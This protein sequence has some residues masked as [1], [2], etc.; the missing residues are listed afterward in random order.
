MKEPILDL[1]L[2]IRLQQINEQIELEQ[3]KMFL[4]ARWI[5]TCYADTHLD[6]DMKSEHDEG[7]KK[8]E[9]ISV[10]NREDGQWYKEQLEFFN[11]K[12]LPVYIKNGNYDS[13]KNFLFPEDKKE[14]SVEEEFININ[15][16]LPDKG[17]DILGKTSPNSNVVYVFR[18]NCHNKNCKE[19]RCS[20]TG[21][22]MLV[23][24]YSWKYAETDEELKQKNEQKSK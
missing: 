4:F 13:A 10:L 22:G 1:N 3:I 12:I 18:C 2:K 16:C 6:S 9:S 8:E 15:E 23:Q 24:I 17:R 7:F 14:I 19:W 20:L 11:Q 21:G 5:S